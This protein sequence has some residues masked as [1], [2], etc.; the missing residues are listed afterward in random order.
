MPHPGE[1]RGEEGDQLRWDFGES[2]TDEPIVD[3]ES[4]DTCGS[5]ATAQ[6]H[7]YLQISATTMHS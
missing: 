7:S 1:R 5:N 4:E 6:P 3:A 2:D